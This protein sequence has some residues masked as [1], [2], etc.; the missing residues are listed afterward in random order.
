MR[1]S[2]EEQLNPLFRRLDTDL[3][4]LLFEL[5]VD[6]YQ[7][8]EECYNSFISHPTVKYAYIASL[9]NEWPFRELIT[10]IEK[11]Y[12]AL[13]NGTTLVKGI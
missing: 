13:C 9:D 1:G 11:S 4:K 2:L 3:L 10:H 6:E 8:S 5:P 12:I 7:V